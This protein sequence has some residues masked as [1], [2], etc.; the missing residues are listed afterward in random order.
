[1]VLSEVLILSLAVL[2][3]AGCQ[4]GRVSDDRDS[5]GAAGAGDE[6]ADPDAVEEPVYY[7]QEG[8][9]P[10][11]AYILENEMIP[12][13]RNSTEGVTGSRIRV[14][15]ELVEQGPYAHLPIERNIRIHTL[16][17]SF[18]RREHFDRWS[19]WYQEDGNTQVFRLFKGETNVR[20][21]R[22]N[23]ARIEAFSAHGWK[24]GDGWQEWVGTVTLVKPTGSIFQV[25]APGPVDW[26]VMIS[27]GGTDGV[28]IQR[29]R[30]ERTRVATGRQFH[31]RVRDNGH[32]YEVYINGRLEATGAWDRQGLRSSFRWGM[33]VGGRRVPEADHM[34]LFTGATVNPPAEDAP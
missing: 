6:A 18:I 17:N 31:L 10:T 27:S 1:M 34:I 16:G 19:R 4:A 23:A 21:R 14:N 25:K 26:G 24:H 22:A 20:N 13:L 11:W 33:Y 8:T 3:L 7:T 28:T 29:R 15:R 12:L 5:S 32:D 30:G 9:D 2:V